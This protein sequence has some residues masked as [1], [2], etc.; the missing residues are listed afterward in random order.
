[1]VFEVSTYINFNINDPKNR[2]KKLQTR[3]NY[4]LNSET[5][6]DTVSLASPKSIRV[7]GLKNN[8]FCIPAKPDAIDR[9][10]TKTVF[11]LSTS[12]I[13]IP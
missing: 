12:I 8:G 1:M 5:R 9:L 4:A 6:V 13:G 3:P 7:F 10:S 2:L 11:E